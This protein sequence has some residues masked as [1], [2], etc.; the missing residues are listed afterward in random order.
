MQRQENGLWKI[1]YLAPCAWNGSKLIQ[2][3]A[4]SCGSL[5]KDAGRLMSSNVLGNEGGA[6]PNYRGIS[7]NP[8]HSQQYDWISK[9]QMPKYKN[10]CRIFATWERAATWSAARRVLG[11]ENPSQG[12]QVSRSPGLQVYLVL[13]SLPSLR[14]PGLPIICEPCQ[15]LPKDSKRYVTHSPHPSPERGFSLAK[16]LFASS[17]ILLVYILNSHYTNFRLIL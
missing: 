17:W 4:M 6:M 1:L 11:K 16:A 9:S 7:G 14:K 8:N 12:F 3:A 13:L 10:F 2:P 5:M 15:N